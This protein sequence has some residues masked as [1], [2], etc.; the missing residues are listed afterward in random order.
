MKIS[1]PNADLR[2]VFSRKTP[3]GRA[4][5][6][7]PFLAIAI[8]LG[9]LA[10]RSYHLSMRMEKALNSFAVHYLVYAAEVTA[11]RTD[12]VA[13]TTRLNAHEQWQQVERSNPAPDFDALQN[14]LDAHPWIVSAIYVPDEDPTNSIYVTELRREESNPSDRKTHDFYTA[15][16]SVRYTYDSRRLL[17]Q[18]SKEVRKQSVLE[19]ASFTEASELRDHSQVQLVKMGSA[20][21]LRQTPEGY[22]I[23]VPLGAP[24]S[25]FAIEA[26]VNTTYASRGWRNHRIVSF[27]F[28]AL[29]ILL[30]AI[31]AMFAVHGLRKEAE[32][33]SLRAA[34]IANVSHELRTPLSMIRLGAE[35]LKRSTRLKP[36]ER[37]DLEDSIL[38]E[39]VHLSHLVENVLDVARLQR[40]SNPFAFTPLDPAELVRSVISTYGSWISSK[41]FE[42]E[43]DLDS[44]VS[45]QMW[46]REA[47][48]RALLNLIDNA[49]KYSSDDRRLRIFLKED[50]DAVSLGVQDHGIG[51]APKDVQR[52]FEPYYRAT[53]SDTQTRRGAGLGLTLVHQIVKSHGGRIEVESTPGEGSVFRLI[54]PKRAKSKVGQASAVLKPTEGILGGIR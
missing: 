41:G 12:V 4:S 13:S 46:D 6:I 10:Y 48:S 14:W 35:T 15:T 45:E 1:L 29:A 19:E 34:L 44:G 21:G 31:G 24:T 52:I 42:L 39:V 23:A 38:R 54:F 5:V 16:G 53:F 43:V 18:A 8:A 28:A 25:D 9:V 47:V 33:M 2:S 36:N 37:A 32:A 27:W 30:V 11:R 49:M 17:Q 22:V 50:A 40:S 26:A 20:R 51:I 3:Y 7:V